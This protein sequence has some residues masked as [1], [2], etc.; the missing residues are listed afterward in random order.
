[1]EHSVR[2]VGYNRQ[3]TTSTLMLSDFLNSSF[4]KK[5]ARVQLDEIIKMCLKTDKR[6]HWLYALSLSAYK[7]EH[8]YQKDASI[9]Q[10]FPNMFFF[11]FI[12][13]ECSIM[14]PSSHH[15]NNE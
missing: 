4:I 14:H 11:V 2:T 6:F 13:L 7:M 15:P 1:M 3:I 10:F 5:D 12:S 8:Y 9:N